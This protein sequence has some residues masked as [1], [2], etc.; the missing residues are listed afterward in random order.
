MEAGAARGG[1]GD[2]GPIALSSGASLNIFVLE[3]S[4][5]QYL[6]RYSEVEARSVGNSPQSFGHVLVLPAF[7][8]NEL[9]LGSLDS[10]PEGNLGPVLTI[11]VVNAIESDVLAQTR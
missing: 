10:I 6:T 7:D 3:K 1:S 8:E 9:L 2:C 5:T 11:V 4:V